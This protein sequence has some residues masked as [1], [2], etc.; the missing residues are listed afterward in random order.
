MVGVCNSFANGVS[1]GVGVRINSSVGVGK[2]GLSAWVGNGVV[3]KGV[4]GI[5]ISV[6]VGS[7]AETLVSVSVGEEIGV[8]LG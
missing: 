3:V 8:S 7:S 5:I 1:E 4:G 6:G 2:E